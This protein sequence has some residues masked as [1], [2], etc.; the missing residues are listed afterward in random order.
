MR[1]LA[2]VLTEEYSEHGVHVANVVIDGLID[3]PGTRALP[4]G[5]AAP[6][7]DHGSREDRRCLLLP[8]H[9]GP[10]LLDARAAADAVSHQAQLLIPGMG[11]SR[12]GMR[13][14]RSFTA[15][16]WWGVLGD[17]VHVDRGPPRGRARSSS[18]SWPT[19][20]RPRELL[21]R[22]RAEPLPL[23]RLHAARRHGARPLQRARRRSVGHGPAGRLARADR[24]GAQ[25]LGVR[26]R[27][28]RAGAP[29]PRGNRARHRLGRRRALVHPAPR[30]GALSCSAARR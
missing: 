30:H 2:Q 6:R 24:A 3:S 5:A 8:A 19:S 20:A 11:Y 15:G 25:R 27:L 7:A 4:H 10:V 23:R 22:D 29:R 18:R 13:D 26:R 12:G 21:A 9:P 1:A 16:G 14:R 17:D 28:R